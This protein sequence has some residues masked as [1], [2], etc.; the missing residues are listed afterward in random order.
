[1]NKKFSIFLVWIVGLLFLIMFYYPILTFIFKPLITADKNVLLESIKNIIISEK[2]KNSLMISIIQASLSAI[3]S[4]VIAFPISYLTS[5]YSFRLAKVLR[6]VSIIPFVL[7][8]IIVIVS[9][10]SMYGKN[11]LINKILGTEFRILYSLIGIVLSHVFYNIS[12]A[13]RFLEDGWNNIDIR[14]RQISKS[15][16]EKRFSFIKN[17][18]LPEMMP[19][20]LSSFFII[21]I[22]SFLSFAI[23]LEF[24]GMQFA[25]LEVQLY[26][27][28][29][30]DISGISPSI[31]G[32]IQ[33]L[34]TLIFVI[35]LVII[36][37]AKK[38]NRTRIIN[39]EVLDLKYLPKYKRRLINFVILMVLLFILLPLVSLFIMSLEKNGYFTLDNYINL[40]TPEKFFMIKI[41]MYE[42]I[43]QSFSISIPAAIITI[44][45]CLF[46]TVF[47]K[48][49]K[50]NILEVYMILPIGISTVSLSYGISFLFRDLFS[51]WIII[52]LV[53]SILAFPISLRLLKANVE[54]IPDSLI[55]IAQSLGAS[56][57]HTF[58]TVELPMYSK[59]I[60][61]A[62]SYAIAISLSEITA[63][64]VIGRGSIRTIP[65]VIYK[66]IHNYQFGQALS[67]STIYIIILLL[68]FSIIDKK[69]LK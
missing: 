28:F 56:R 6:G 5:R 34:I 39:T 10:L 7:P 41:N 30:N 65:M 58:R 49:K 37:N 22:Y 54:K 45:I 25:T 62:L 32:L 8:S 53:H 38:R 16:G 46:V 12:I 4:I 1:M 20:F 36:G 29:I 51:P 42:V 19:Y 3:I 48:G 44:I 67:L 52:V 31:Y 60:A 24:G 18:V 35:S 61:N 57:L 40:F 11:G 9:M 21:F 17:V 66:F 59:G 15:L 55:F 14:Y 47:I 43:F 64:F 2:F 68:I 50:S 27:T 23:V 69:I 13:Y 33:M 63:V 26:K